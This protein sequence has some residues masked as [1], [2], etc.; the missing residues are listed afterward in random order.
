MVGSVE[1][2]RQLDGL[3]IHVGAVH[4]R[5][6]VDERVDVD[7]FNMEG[8]FAA[9]DAGEVQQIVDQ[10]GLKLDAAAQRLNVLLKFGGKALALF[11]GGERDQNRRQGGAKLVREGS[12]EIVLGDVGGFGFFLGLLE[13]FL[14]LLV[15]GKVAEDQDDAVDDGVLAADRGA[16]VVD[17]DF[18]AVLSDQQR[19][20]RQ[21]LN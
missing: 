18:R 9:D 11:P 6:G 14:V 19:M 4:A 21:A 16:A 5:D 15:L 2:E 7:V 17:G 10:P 12:E 3:G 13:V 20:I 8:E 1:P